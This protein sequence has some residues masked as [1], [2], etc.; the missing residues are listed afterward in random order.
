MEKGE[1]QWELCDTCD[2]ATLIVDF[3]YIQNVIKDISP[4]HRAGSIHEIQCNFNLQITN[5]PRKIGKLQLREVLVA[6][7]AAEA[8]T[9]CVAQCSQCKTRT[10]THTNLQHTHCC[11]YCLSVC[12]SAK[13]HKKPHNNFH[14]HT[15]SHNIRKKCRR[16]SGNS[17]FV[18]V[19]AFFVSASLRV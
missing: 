11:C 14:T 9:K 5:P 2:L 4:A 10:H 6:A 18:S 13:G 15:H 16:L 17:F 3:Q 12:L 8:A 19:P 1:V 7:A